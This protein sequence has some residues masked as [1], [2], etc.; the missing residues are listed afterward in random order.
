MGKTS[1]KKAQDAAGSPKIS[2]RKSPGGGDP[3]DTSQALHDAPVAWPMRGTP[4]QYNRAT[5]M[6]VVKTTIVGHGFR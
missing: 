2:S 6:P 3:L 4:T 1:T 5:K